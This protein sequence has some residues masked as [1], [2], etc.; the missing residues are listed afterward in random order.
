MNFVL[1][2][3]AG[4]SRNWGG[5]LAAEAFEYL[6]GCPEIVREPRLR[7]LLW[8]HQPTGGFEDALAELQAAYVRDPRANDQ[9]LM[10]F[11]TAVSRMF[12]ACEAFR[13]AVHPLPHMTVV[14]SLQEIATV[15]TGLL[16]GA[17]RIR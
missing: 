6:L 3:G 10:A 13:R 15:R 7:S 4:F 1:L 17:S 9:Q 5:W 14:T 16:A 2:L 8:K 12:E 11:Q